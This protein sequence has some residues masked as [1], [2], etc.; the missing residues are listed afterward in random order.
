M[1]REEAFKYFNYLYQY[2]T[3]K[4]GIEAY[5]IAL[6]V[7]RGPQPDPITGLVPCGCA[8]KP[9]YHQ[10]E[11]GYIASVKVSVKCSVCKSST[12]EFVEFA[13]DDAD[14]VTALKAIAR[15]AWNAMRGY[16]EWSYEYQK[17]APFRFSHAVGVCGFG[18]YDY[19]GHMA[20]ADF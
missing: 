9:E 18:S 20:C 8:G 10:H 12:A 1:N 2:V 19:L 6:S 16:K 14:T 13:Y 15:G 11:W 5:Q 3:T 4:D 17:E 7:L